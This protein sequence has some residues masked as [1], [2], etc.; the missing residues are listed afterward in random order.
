MP[1]Q[2]SVEAIERMRSKTVP[3][4]PQVDGEAMKTNPPLP[5]PLPPNPEKPP[6]PPTK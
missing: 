5:G 1:E 2:F 6:A 4:I 3:S